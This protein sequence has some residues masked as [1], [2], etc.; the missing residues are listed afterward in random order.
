[1]ESEAEDAVE[2]AKGL[3]ILLEQHATIQVLWKLKYKGDS[4]NDEII[5]VIG[6]EI[7]SGR[8]KVDKWLRAEPLAILQS[9]NVVVSVHHGGANSFYEAVKYVYRVY[10]ILPAY[11]PITH[12]LLHAFL[13]VSNLAE[14]PSAP[15]SWI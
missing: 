3:R 4:H 11:F 8:V 10:T 13:V 12:S 14:F 6:K 2:I 15:V 9:G 1:M 5:H 7:A